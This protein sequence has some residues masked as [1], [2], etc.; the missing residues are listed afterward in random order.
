[1]SILDC[2]ITLSVL[3][4][5]LSPILLSSTL[6][7][8]LS[9]VADDTVTVPAGPF[10]M[11]LDHP[12]ATDEKP[13]RQVQVQTVTIDRLEVS[14]ASFAAFVAVTG[15]QT[16]AEKAGAA[17]KKDGISWHHPYG[18]NSTAAPNHP[19]VYINWHDAQA[20]C[21]WRGGRLPTEAE[22]EK[23]ARSNDRRSWPWGMSFTTTAANH[24]GEDDGFAGLAP[25]DSFPTG[26]GPYGTLNQGG[27][28]WEWCADWYA[29]DY[30]TTGSDENPPG[31]TTGHLKILRGGSSINQPAALRS[32]NRFK[33]LPIERSPYIGF[34]CAYSP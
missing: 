31:P 4:Y 19:V 13:S 7:Q 25:V 10:T 21:T 18:P 12:R 2:R 17:E 9:S 15:Y 3:I 23:S 26:Q 20:Y 1:M 5:I 8:P 32:T 16:A 34:R 22:W 27:N 6:A 33:V 14:N 11:G 29:A 30:Y 24:W 28:V